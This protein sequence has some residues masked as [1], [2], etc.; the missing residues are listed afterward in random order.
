MS[1]PTPDF[2][3]GAFDHLG[4]L[5]ACRTLDPSLVLLNYSNSEDRH[6][7]TRGAQTFPRTTH[8]DN[9]NRL[10]R[11][12][13]L[14]PLHSVSG[15]RVPRFSLSML[16]AAAISFRYLGVKPP[17]SYPTPDFESG[18]FDHL[19]HLS[20][21]CSK[22]PVSKVRAAL[23]ILSVLCQ[24][25]APSKA[26]PLSGSSVHCPLSTV[27]CPLTLWF[28][29]GEGGITL[30]APA[31]CSGAPRVPLFFIYAASRQLLHFGIL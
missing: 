7:G 31:L 23:Q 13:R 3:S 28:T 10:Q 1:C 15:R 25:P 27:F 18:A 5:S 16:P 12:L 14:P 11:G 9:S 20:V 2:E 22:P 8:G 24:V 29:G 30:T 21:H 4:H 19:G 17:V 26:Q 6:F